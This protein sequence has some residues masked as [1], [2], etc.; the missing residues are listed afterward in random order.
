MVVSRDCGPPMGMAKTVWHT[1]RTQRPPP[2]ALLG[3][4]GMEGTLFLAI[5]ILLGAYVLSR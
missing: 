2:S 5:A 4:G 1:A 3:E